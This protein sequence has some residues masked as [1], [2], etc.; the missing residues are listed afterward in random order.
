[1]TP[2]RV[3]RGSIFGSEPSYLLNNSS[4]GVGGKVRFWLRITLSCTECTPPHID[5]Q[6]KVGI[7]VQ[8]QRSATVQ[9][10]DLREG[11]PRIKDTIPR[12]AENAI[13]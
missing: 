2:W 1:M 10:R 6:A 7:L 13:G 12:T 3:T 4:E 8:E 11:I 5:H 9:C